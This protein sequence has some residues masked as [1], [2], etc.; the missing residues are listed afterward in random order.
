MPTA[1]IEHDARSAEDYKKQLYR[2][3]IAGSIGTTTRPA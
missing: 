2:A 3:V 1:T